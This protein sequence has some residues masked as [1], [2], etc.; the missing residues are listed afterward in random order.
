MTTGWPIVVNGRTWNE[1]DFIGEN[2]ATSL[3]LFFQDVAQHYGQFY[4]ATSTTSISVGTGT[5]SLTVQTGKPFAIG[6][7]VRIVR[8]ADPV[9]V[10]MDGT[11]TAFTSSTGA[12]TVLVAGTPTGSGSYSDWTIS[13]LG[14]IGPT[15]AKGAVGPAP[16][17]A[18]TSTATLPI[19]LGSTGAFA[20]AA[21]TDLALGS[22]VLIA[23]QTDPS[24][25]MF[26]TLTARSGATFTVNV[27]AISESGTYSSWYLTLSG[28]QGI[29][30]TQGV[31]G[32]TG[33]T[34]PAVTLKTTSTT[35]L[36][37]GPGSFSF[38]TAAA[39]DLQTGQYLTLASAAD[40]AN[41]MTGRITAIAGTSVSIT[42]GTYDWGGSGTRADW[43][44][45]ISGAKGAKGDTGAMGPY[46]TPPDATTSVK[47]IVRL[48]SSAVAIAGSDT[49]RAVTPAALAAVLDARLDDQEDDGM[50]AL[51]ALPQQGRRIDL[52]TGWAVNRRLFQ[53]TGPSAAEVTQP[54]GKIAR[55][56]RRYPVPSVLSA[57]PFT[58]Q[59][60]WLYPRFDNLLPEDT[61]LDSGAYA[62]SNATLTKAS[63]TGP[64]GDTLAD[65]ALVTDTSGSVYG[66]R[67]YTRTV[68][69]DGASYL[70]MV[71]MKAGNAAHG[72]LRMSLTGGTGISRSVAVQYSNGALS[73][74]ADTQF[75]LGGADALPN[76]WYRVWGVIAN[77]STGNTTLTVSIVPAGSAASATANSY[78]RKAMLARGNI[79]LPFLASSRQEVPSTVRTA[80]SNFRNLT[81]AEGT[82]AVRG[83][84]P[85]SS[86]V[87]V[88]AQ[89]DDN[90]DST[91]IVLIRL[92]D[93]SA[94][95]RFYVAGT[96]VRDLNLGTWA[97]DTVLGAIVAWDASSAS[98]RLDGI[99]T[100]TSSVA[101]NYDGAEVAY[102]RLGGSLAEG[103][104]WGGTVSRFDHRPVRV[105]DAGLQAIVA[106]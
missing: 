47:G 102:L 89:I 68:T 79:K 94:R 10:V 29:Q 45:G 100:V 43:N 74:G 54:N 15:G 5:R 90:S 24:K 39:L 86:R 99:A 64:D 52:T 80:A 63:V 73:A 44:V 60:M 12:M 77:N 83:R 8:T 18:T 26:G 9:G 34:G 78:M 58:R 71:Q 32:L 42:V 19:Q 57:S 69:N 31:Q 6:Q 104:E 59:G 36:T 48:A 14:G 4:T 93:N 33:A 7:P 61:L 70:F 56:F 41:Y 27:L 97:N 40:T 106:A 37:I 20:V 96:L 1:S 95:A 11:L 53:T 35:S 85:I 22:L 13:V 21:S 3:P 30:G 16:T 75:T 67:T 2:Y 17:I 81:F 101:V 76:S 105:A 87:G 82:L 72:M 62:L 38:T 50:T 84:S 55:T 66:A 49:E 103:S 92:A 46:G 25:F 88:L 91:R 51:P 98:G 28:P 23:N 65:V